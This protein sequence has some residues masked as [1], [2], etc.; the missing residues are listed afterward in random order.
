[1]ALRQAAHAVGY[2]LLR[3]FDHIGSGHDGVGLNPDQS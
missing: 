3:A 1:M 2:G